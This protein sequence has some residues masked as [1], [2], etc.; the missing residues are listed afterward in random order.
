MDKLLLALKLGRKR[1]VIEAR[2][3]ARQI[4]ALLGFDG[5][6]QACL[7]AGVF[8]LACQ[9]YRKQ[10]GATVFF[11]VKSRSLHVSFGKRN[12]MFADAPRIEKALPGKPFFAASDI[13]W[14]VRQLVAL[15]TPS[16]FDEV[17]KLNQDLLQALLE[18]RRDQ[19]PVHVPRL[20]RD[21]T[22]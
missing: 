1:D 21:K 9:V 12:R 6:D 13:K 18:S 3:R 19:A 4:A 15:S 17:D 16:V 11:Q 10:S 2:Q 22:A 14:M 8:A 7:A 5:R 20:A